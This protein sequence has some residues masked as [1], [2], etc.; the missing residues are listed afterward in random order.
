MAAQTDQKIIFSDC[1]TKIHFLPRQIVCEE[2]DKRDVKT[3]AQQVV[4]H[5]N[6][7]GTNCACMT[8][9]FRAEFDGILLFTDRQNEF[10][11][12]FPDTAHDVT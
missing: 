12:P 8:R 3:F 2:E 6:E 1:T 10:G 4:D 7:N 11:K 9:G 5:L